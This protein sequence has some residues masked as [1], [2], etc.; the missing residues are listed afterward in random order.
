MLRLGGGAGFLNSVV[1]FAAAIETLQNELD[2]FDF[3]GIIWS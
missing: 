2:P 3:H 1:H